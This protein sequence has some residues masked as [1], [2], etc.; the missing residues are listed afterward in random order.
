MF[1]KKVGGVCE[2]P[3]DPGNELRR[4]EGVCEVPCDPGNELRRCVS[5]LSLC[6]LCIVGVDDSEEEEEEE[7][8]EVVLA[9]TP[10][11]LRL[12]SERA[13]RLSLN[14][15]KYPPY[16]GIEGPT[17][18]K[19]PQCT[20]WDEYL[21]MLWPQSLC[22]LIVAETNRYARLRKKGNW[23]DVDREEMWTFMGINILM[24]IH[25]LPRISNYW[26]RDGLLGIPALKRYM[27][28]NRFW[29]IWTNL[30]VV[31]NS[32][33]SPSEGLSR[34]FKPVL[35]VLSESF[36]LHYNPGQEMC[37]DE[38]MV[39]YK[40]HI[41]GKVRMP[42]KPIKMGFKIWCCCCCSCCGYLCT[43]QVYEGKPTDPSTGKQVPEKGMVKRVVMELASPFSGLNHV[44]Y[45]DNFFTSGPLVSELYKEEIYVAGTIQQRAAGFPNNLKDTRPARGSYVVE[46]VG[47]I[48]Y[49]VFHDRNLVSFVTNA[50]PE[51]MEGKVARVHPDGVIRYQSVPPLLPAYNKFMGAVDRLSQVRRNYGFDRKSKR[52]WIRPFFQFFDY[53]VNNAHILYMHDCKRQGIQPKD[54]LKFRLGLV[55]L[56]LSPTRGNTRSSF[57]IDV[58]G[59]GG[60]QLVHL[61]QMQ[62]PRGRCL[63]CLRKKKKKHTT[64]GCS[65]CGVRLCKT[66]CFAEFHMEGHRQ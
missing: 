44:L 5:S 28:R 52:Y 23:A 7:E 51:E 58:R 9:P 21:Y 62:M 31:D 30:H 63:Q 57:G 34:K 50:F 64:F 22:D 1:V 41:K 12:K 8:K 14:S 25:R 56:L 27:C 18:P 20:D 16:L 33:L 54:L 29:E 15:G 49:Y 43:F 4:W 65:F 61:S 39:K 6:V 3:C 26:S 42:K 48:C 19:D 55:R 45:L 24:G 2:V 17:E 53:A 10:K 13:L 40:G 11:V 60:C 59:V 38:A 35:D 36:F 46:R 37:V 66:T 47:N 32:R